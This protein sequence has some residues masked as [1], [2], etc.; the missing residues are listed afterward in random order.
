MTFEVIEVIQPQSLHLILPGEAEGKLLAL[1]I[2]KR[3]N[4]FCHS[5]FVCYVFWGKISF[6][7]VKFCNSFR[8]V[9][10]LSFLIPHTYFPLLF[11]SYTSMWHPSQL[12]VCFWTLWSCKLYFPCF[13]CKRLQKVVEKISSRNWH[14]TEL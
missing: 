6:K 3:C 2:L 7:I 13:I 1:L 14:N 4:L 9:E 5:N 10:M 11:T 8:F 12:C